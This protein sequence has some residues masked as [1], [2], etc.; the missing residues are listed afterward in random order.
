[1]AKFILIDKGTIANEISP[2]VPVVICVDKSLAKWVLKVMNDEHAADKTNMMLKE[3]I[4]TLKRKIIALEQKL[5]RR[6]KYIQEKSV[7]VPGKMS[8]EIENK[9][10]KKHRDYKEKLCPGA[11]SRGPHM[12]KP[13]SGRQTICDACK[14]TLSLLKKKTG[15]VSAGKTICTKWRGT[16]QVPGVVVS[17]EPKVASIQD[18][19][20]IPPKPIAPVV[21]EKPTR[22]KVEDVLRMEDGP[23]KKA[24]EAQFTLAEKMEAS[25]LRYKI[26]R[27]KWKAMR[28]RGFGL[29]NPIVGTGC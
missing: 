17:P 27:E 7:S 26:E 24:L 22:P 13:K 9:P 25:K 15:N 16:A 14:E 23:E 8:S 1:M 28:N 2:A 10:V 5:S 19:D 20:L 29:D 18:K 11:G 6:D 21:A 4:K 12:F 3:D